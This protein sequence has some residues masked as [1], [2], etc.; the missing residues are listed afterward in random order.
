VSARHLASPQARLHAALLISIASG[1]GVVCW[2]GGAV[3][4]GA[5]LLFELFPRLLKINEMNFI[6]YGTR[7]NDTSV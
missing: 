6:R 1:V 7:V 5:F 3:F 4:C 2:G